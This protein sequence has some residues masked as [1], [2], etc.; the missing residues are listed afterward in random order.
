MCTQIPNTTRPGW[1]SNAVNFT[2]RL[3]HPSTRLMLESR[4][5]PA[6]RILLVEDQKDAAQMLSAALESLEKGFEVVAV[7]S[8]EEAL[9]ALDKGAFDL[10]MADVMLPGISGLELMA[11]FR[12]RNPNTKVILLSGVRD[13]EIRKQVVRSGAEAFFFKPVELSDLLDAVE[14]LF[15]IAESFLPSE[16]KMMNRELSAAENPASD[17]A[18]QLSELR[19]NLQALSVALINERGQILARAGALPDDEIETSLMPH[20]MSAFFAAGRIAAFAKSSQPDDLQVFRGKTYHL[21]LSSLGSTYALLVVT[22]PLAAAR[23]AAQAEAIQKAIGRVA[24]QLNMLEKETKPSPTNK[25]TDL[26]DTDPHLES[27]LEK[28][29]TKPMSRSQTDKYWKSKEKELQPAPR[30][31]SLTYEQAVQLGLAPGDK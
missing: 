6:K 24:P 23:M 11:R 2:A 3:S 13:P 8:A 30:P 19:F 31:G 12:R 5:M 9:N 10:L 28:A 1:F 14:R 15:G 29:E 21:H 25:S 27:L 4:V 18:E 26:E 20:L 17:V 7:S 22:K 16:M